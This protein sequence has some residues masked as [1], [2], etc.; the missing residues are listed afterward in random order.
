MAFQLF[1]TKRTI[2]YYE[3]IEENNLGNHICGDVSLAW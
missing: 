3:N 1:N 2:Y